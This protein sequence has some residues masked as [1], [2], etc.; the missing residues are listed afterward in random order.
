LI[1]KIDGEEAMKFIKE[2]PGIY[3]EALFLRF[4]ENHNISEI[5]AEIGESPN[6]VSVRINRGLKKLKKAIN[7]KYK[8]TQK[9]R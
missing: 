9:E 8:K 1:D 7:E 2:L 3:S 4:V 5:A 6:I